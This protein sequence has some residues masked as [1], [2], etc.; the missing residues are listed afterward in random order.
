MISFVLAETQAYPSGQE[1][2]QYY[3]GVSY[4]A[5]CFGCGRFC[6]SSSSEGYD[7][8]WNQIYVT[9]KCAKCGDITESMV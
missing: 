4:S 2:E 3:P 9:T 6:K 1:P 5:N 8:T 7:G